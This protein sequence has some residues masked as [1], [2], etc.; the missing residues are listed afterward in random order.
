MPQAYTAQKGRDFIVK[1]GT[2]V[3]E[4]TDKTINDSRTTSDITTDYFLQQTGT[5]DEQPLDREVEL[6]CTC[7]VP[8]YGETN[9]A[10]DAVETAYTTNVQLTGATAVKITW[11]ALDSGTSYNGRVKQFN[12]SGNPGE[13]AQ[14]DI[15]IRLT[16]VVG[17]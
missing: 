8:D 11:D 17:S 10:Y 5:R 15:V 7:P 1:I 13:Y 9:T 16:A 14:A 2:A 3:L 12:I 4:C 6:N